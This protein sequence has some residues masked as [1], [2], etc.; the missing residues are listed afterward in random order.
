VIELI[1]ATGNHT[2]KRKF[3]IKAVGVF[4][5]GALA[6][7]LLGKYAGANS[8]LD[9]FSD[10]EQARILKETFGTN[11]AAPPAPALVELDM[12]RPVRLAIGG[13]GLADEEQN[14]RLGDLLTAELTGGLVWNW[15]SVRN[16]KRCWRNCS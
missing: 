8:T 9:A 11:A 12:R 1:L 4:A 10:E 16:W 6:I 2:V 14:Q 15:W 13:V 7:W 3:L 5:V